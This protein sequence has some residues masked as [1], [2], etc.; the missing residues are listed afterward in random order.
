MNL[1]IQY[2]LL[3]L[4]LGLG[5]GLGFI[6][7]CR[8]WRPW[9]YRTCAHS[10]TGSASSATYS[11]TVPTNSYSSRTCN[12]PSYSSSTYRT[13]CVANS[14]STRGSCIYYG[15]SYNGYC[16][17]TSTY[18]CPDFYSSTYS[19]YCR[20]YSYSTSC[21]YYSYSSCSSYTYRVCPSF[22]SY[23]YSTR[24]VANSYSTRSTPP[25]NYHASYT[26]GGGY[27]PN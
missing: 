21:R 8:I 6:L 4:V 19:T 15:T 22:C 20:A 5:L 1:I 25:C 26:I 23:S 12:C 17:S 11:S 9:H 24:C 14:Y 2:G 7:Y 18:R 16:P 27:C 3:G 13:Y 10:H